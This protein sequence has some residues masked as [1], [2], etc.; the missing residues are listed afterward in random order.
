MKACYSCGEKAIKNGVYK[1]HIEDFIKEQLPKDN[2]HYHKKGAPSKLIHGLK[3]N[4][5]VFYFATKRRPITSKILKFEDAYGHLTNSGCTKTDSKGNAKF[6]LHCPQVYKSL[7]GKIYSRHIH[8]VYWNDKKYCWELNL[9]THE[10]ICHVDKEYV[11]KHASKSLIIDALPEKYYNREHIKGAV[12]LPYNKRVSEKDVLLL[13]KKRGFK[14]LNKNIPIIVY[15]YNKACN[16]SEKLI[17]KL[18]KL[19]F[20]NIVDYNSGIKGWDGAKE[21]FL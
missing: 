19:G 5:C 12:N 20:H 9:Y 2:K 11:K 15:C 1:A 14:T 21:S 8:F 6:F 7:N 13:M 17:K 3:P 18:D 4:T 16:A 10:I